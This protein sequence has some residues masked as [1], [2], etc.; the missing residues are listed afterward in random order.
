MTNRKSNRQSKNIISILGLIFVTTLFSAPAHAVR[1]G[2]WQCHCNKA[3]ESGQFS[4]GKTETEAKENCE[5]G[6]N[7]KIPL[8]DCYF[9]E[10]TEEDRN[11]STPGIAPG[12]ERNFSEEK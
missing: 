6:L 4:I 8:S 10:L 7:K 12:E 9:W 1:S 11:E 5:S 2:E 3:G